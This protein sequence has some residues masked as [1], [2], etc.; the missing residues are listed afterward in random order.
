[1]VSRTAPPIL[2]S[3]FQTSCQHKP[4]LLANQWSAQARS[5]PAEWGKQREK[6]ACVSLEHQAHNLGTNSTQ[7]GVRGGQCLVLVLTFS[8]QTYTSPGTCL[9]SYD[10][11]L[12]HVIHVSKAWLSH[13][14][15]PKVLK[16]RDDE[17]HLYWAKELTVITPVKGQK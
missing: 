2:T 4:P 16:K 1:M 9:Q 10:A 11:A 6:P 3:P 5:W 17:W 15:I 13:H 7:S 8:H 14:E 12:S